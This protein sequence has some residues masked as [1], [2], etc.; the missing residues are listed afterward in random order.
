MW[1]QCGYIH[2]GVIYMVADAV[3]RARVNGKVKEEAADILAATGLTLSDAF[4]MLLV[5]VVEDRALPFDP[6]MP[7][8]KTIGAMRETRKGGLIRARNVGSLLSELNAD[9]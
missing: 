7:S 6:L 1:L 2:K 8:E 3:V 4:R 5:R 9:D